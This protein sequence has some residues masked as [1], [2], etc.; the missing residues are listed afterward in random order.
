MQFCQLAGYQMLQIRDSLLNA[1]RNGL[2]NST[3]LSTLLNVRDNE[4]FI[5]HTV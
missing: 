2:F 5:S 3:V 1:S 4:Q